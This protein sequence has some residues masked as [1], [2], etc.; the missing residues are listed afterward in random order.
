MEQAEKMR[1]IM[2]REFMRST[3]FQSCITVGQNCDD[4]KILEWLK[5]DDVTSCNYKALKGNKMEKELLEKIKYLR[6]KTNCPYWAIKC[7][8]ILNDY[9]V[10][11]AYKDI[12]SIYYIIGDYP[13]IAVKRNEEEL[14]ERMKRYE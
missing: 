6:E 8:L 11:K 12:A 10:D 14:K 5:S 7:C 3:V 13:D 1:W 4:L 9:D 2:T